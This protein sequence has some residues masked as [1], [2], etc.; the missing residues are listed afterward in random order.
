MSS[1]NFHPVSEQQRL[2]EGWLPLAEEASRHYGWNLDP[3]GLEV[4]VLRAAPELACSRTALE[5]RLSLWVTYQ[6]TFTSDGQ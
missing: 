5:A 6:Q 4:L 3:T 1:A 2:L